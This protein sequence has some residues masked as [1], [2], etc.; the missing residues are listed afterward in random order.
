MTN[1]IPIDR[2]FGTTGKPP[3]H[4]DR[5]GRP[6]IMTGEL[7]QDGSPRA[8]TCQKHNDDE[9]GCQKP[10]PGIPYRRVTTFI[11]VIGDRT[12][13]EKWKMRSVALGL[14]RQPVLMSEVSAVADDKRALDK[15]CDRALTAGG[16]TEKRDHG[17]ALHRLTELMDL[18]GNPTLTPADLA[19]VKAY[20]KACADAGIRHL[21]IET[22]TVHDG[23]LVA[24]TFDRLVEIDGVRYIADIKT[25]DIDFDTRKVAMQMAMY[26]NGKRYDLA[27]GERSELQADPTRGLIIHLPAGEARCDL[28]WVDL[29]LGH[30]YNHLAREVWKA[31][32]DGNTEVRTGA[33]AAVGSLLRMA[34]NYDALDALWQANAVRWNDT[35]T[36]IA[37]QRR[38]ELEAS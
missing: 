13:L 26:A 11:D 30:R 4:R 36:A 18:G 10:I 23:W 15:V 29:E 5:W 16:A 6:I 17:K 7:R 28:V 19:D 1:V 25:G 8:T 37:R 35:L 21:E 24:G 20:M 33:P 31:R 34:G 38:A 32:D 22:T 3:I 14:L 2:A 9:P 12:Q 27:T